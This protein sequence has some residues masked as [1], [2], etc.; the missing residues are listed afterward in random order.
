MRSGCQ[1]SNGNRT[2]PIQTCHRIDSDYARCVALIGD[3]DALREVIG[4]PTELVQRR[5]PT[6]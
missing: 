1:T 2:K 6:A 5:S 3:E 4:Q